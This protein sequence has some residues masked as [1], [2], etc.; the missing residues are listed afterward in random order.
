VASLPR[1]PLRR[2]ETLL[3]V[4]ITVM[5]VVLS[6]ATDTFLT[7]R[8]LSDLLT[9]NAFMAIAAAGLVVVLVSG[10]IDISFAAIASVAQYAA[11][12]ITVRY[13]GTWLTLMALAALVGA[14][15]GS[16]N[17]LVI[18]QSGLKSIIVTIATL[19]IFFGFLMFA[20][21]GKYISTLPGWFSTGVNIFEYVDAD[22]MIHSINLQMIG[23]VLAFLLSWA[24]L[25][26]TS[27]GRQIYAVGGNADAARRIGFDLFMINLVAFSYMGALAGVAAVIQAQLTQQVIPSSLVGREL[28]VLAAVVLGGASLAGGR[29]TV[30][31]TILGVALLSILQ[32][33]LILLGVS[34]YWLQAFVGGVIICAVI[35]TA[36]EGQ[37]TRR[38]REV[39]A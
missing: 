5:V 17:A 27:L 20:T 34:S 22:E 31:G 32:N 13:G 24:L 4:V 1:L 16:V 21:G 10:G 12:L 26:K 11:I 33:G 25:S 6:F 19:N 23:I 9:A 39:A 28:D 18:R 36:L 37:G 38:M 8:N 7:I 15:L 29:G 35:V 30:L 2:H 3:A 14:L